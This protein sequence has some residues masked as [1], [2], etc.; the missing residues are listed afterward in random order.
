MRSCLELGLHLDDLFV[1]IKGH[2]VRPLR[3]DLPCGARL[4]LEAADQIRV[5]GEDHHRGQAELRQA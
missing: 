4:I 2:V 3:R 1:F 5:G